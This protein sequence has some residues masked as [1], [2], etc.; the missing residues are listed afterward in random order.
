VFGASSN[1]RDLAED[2]FRVGGAGVKAGVR[3]ISDVKI[4][5]NG[6]ESIKQHLGNPMFTSGGGKINKGNQA[7]I[8]RLEKIAE[9]KM[10]ATDVDLHFYAHETR[11]FELMNGNYTEE[12]YDLFH[13][14]AAKEY[15][16]KAVDEDT[17][18]YTSEAYK[19]LW[20]D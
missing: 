19:L 1:A 11:E 20:E 5:T 4:Q 17:T 14:Q 18:F 13:G 7:M 3:S 6:I 15:G 2:G 12:S 8:D 10:E 16:V 9:G